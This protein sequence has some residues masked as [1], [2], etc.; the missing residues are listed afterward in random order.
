M[1][2][3]PRQLRREWNFFPVKFLVKM[4]FVCSVEGN[5]C[6]SMIPLCT[7]SWM[8]YMW[9]SMCF[10]FLPLNWISI[11]LQSALVVTPDDDQPMK[12]NAQLSEKM[13]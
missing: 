10:S 3:T 11:E 6:R 1:S 4:F 5:N 7:K 2:L 13:L 8:Y 9:I 12:L